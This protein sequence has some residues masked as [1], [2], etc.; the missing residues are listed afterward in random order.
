MQSPIFAALV[1]AG[2]TL[3]AQSPMI[4]GL[5]HGKFVSWTGS[6]R[7]GEITVVNAS[8][9]SSCQFD[10]RTYF[11][12]DHQLIAVRGLSPGDPLE[13]VADRKPG[14]PACYARTV[15]VT[16]AHARLFTP[17][18]RPP[19]RTSVSPTESFAP[20][21]D[22][23][24]GGR[25]LR[26]DAQQ[27]VVLTRTREIHLQV[28]RDTHFAGDGLSLDAQ[29]LPVN[30]HVFVRAGHNIDGRLEAYRVVWGDIV[31]PQ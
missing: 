25:V 5:V 20:R 30:A 28:R 14:S 8:G 16:E 17:G 29:S 3:H 19:L 22:V 24:F 27:I 9:M 23:I 1:L 12:R 26:C 10:S 15:Q 2:A 4:A 31:A 18:V 6:L 7:S 21:G 11:E 13:V